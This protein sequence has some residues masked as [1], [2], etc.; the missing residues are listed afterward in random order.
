MKQTNQITDKS[1][2]ETKVNSKKMKPN[3]KEEIQKMIEEGTTKAKEIAEKTGLSLNRVYEIRKELGHGKKRK[4]KT[5]E[6]K[7]E[8]MTEKEAEQYQKN[9]EETKMKE[10]Q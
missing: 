9:T 6:N 5:K 2:H 7:E 10:N 3:K 8:E 1:R 4:N